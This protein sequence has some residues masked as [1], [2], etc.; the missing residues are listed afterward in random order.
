MHRVFILIQQITLTY[1]VIAVLCRQNP[2]CACSSSLP[3]YYRTQ[4]RCT[5]FV[6]VCLWLYHRTCG[7]YL[8]LAL[9]CSSHVSQTGNGLPSS[10]PSARVSLRSSGSTCSTVM[11]WNILLYFNCGSSFSGWRL[12]SRHLFPTLHQ[13]NYLH[14]QPGHIYGFLTGA[15]AAS[16]LS[17]LRHCQLCA[18]SLETAACEQAVGESVALVL[19]HVRGSHR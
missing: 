3:S 12:R 2:E 16:A 19:L 6:L 10:S 17:A 7:P 15:D 4:L 18:F 9:F 8:F 1:F 14:P 5:L 11:T 13:C